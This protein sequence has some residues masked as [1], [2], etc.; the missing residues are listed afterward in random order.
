[1][2]GSNPRPLACEASVIATTPTRLLSVL[3]TKPPRDTSLS[4]GYIYRQ[5]NGL[6]PVYSPW[7]CAQVFYKSKFGRSN[8]ESECSGTVDFASAVSGFCGLLRRA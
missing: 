7:L 5:Q 1:M 4:I 8:L 6:V 2:R 3:L